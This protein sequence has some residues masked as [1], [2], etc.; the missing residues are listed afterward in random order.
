MILVRKE[1]L[2][3]N[4]FHNFLKDFYFLI[5][6]YD[7]N[8]IKFFLSMF[9][10]NLFFLIPLFY[11][12]NYFHLNFKKNHLLKYFLFLHQYVKYHLHLIFNFIINSNY[13][14][15]DGKIINL[16]FRINSKLII[17]FL[18]I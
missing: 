5:L 7:F 15:I 8:S 13:V 10:F 4:Y 12:R 16:R 6:N 3:T 11:F 1:I 14:R 18:I 17:F 2:F 9:F